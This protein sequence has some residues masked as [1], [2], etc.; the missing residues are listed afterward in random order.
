MDNPGRSLYFGGS[1]HVDGIRAPDQEEEEEDEEENRKREAEIQG[2]LANAF[3]DLEDDESF[4]Q[5]SGYNSFAFGKERRDSAYY[6]D[7]RGRKEEG[8]EASYRHYDAG[9]GQGD[10]VFDRFGSESQDKR[11]EFANREIYSEGFSEHEQLGNGILNGD[12]PSQANSSGSV[13]P[14]SDDS[15][16]EE[17]SQRF[18]PLAYHETAHDPYHITAH[19]EHT[20]LDLDP[21]DYRPD[22]HKDYRETS[23][24]Y[25]NQVADYQ[26]DKY[27]SLVN[28]ETQE[29]VTEADFRAADTPQDQMKLLYEARGRELDRLSSELS[30]LKF[31]SSRDIRV[32]QHQINLVTSDSESKTANINQLQTLLSEKEERIKSMAGDLK[33]LQNKLSTKENENKKLHFELETAQSTLSSLECQIS[34]LKAADTLTRNQKLHEDFVTKLKQGNEE[35]RE[36]LINKLQDAQNQAEQNQKEVTRLREELRSLRATYDESLVQK[37]EAVTKLTVTNET[38]RRQ[39]EDLMKSH[40]GQQIIELQIKVRSL[41]AIKEKLENQVCSLESEVEKAK[42]E[43]DG[44]D[45]AIKLGILSEVIPGE[46]SMVQ[47]GIKKALNYDD[48]IPGERQAAGEKYTEAQEKLKL[49]DELKRSLMS[50]KAKRDEICH[51]QEEASGKQLQIKKLESELKSAQ[52]EIKELKTNLLRMELA[53]EEKQLKEKKETKTDDG[54]LTAVCAE[55]IGLKEE[56]ILLH[57]SLRGFEE[58]FTAVKN[59]VENY[60]Q[61]LPNLSQETYNECMRRFD[62]LNAIADL[63]SISVKDVKHY[64]DKISEMRDKNNNI[65]KKQALWEKQVDSVERKLKVFE[66]MIVSA[67]SDKGSGS[68]YGHAVNVLER[69]LKDFIEQTGFVKDDIRTLHST[70]LSLKD[71]LTKA[72]LQVVE[73][74]RAISSL[75]KEKD[76]HEKNMDILAEEKE[77]E[78]K[79]ALGDCQDTYMRFHEDAMKELETKMRK[80]YENISDI[81]KKEVARLAD[82][83]SD[84]KKMYISVCEEKKE[85]ED[86][87]KVKKGDNTEFSETPVIQSNTYRVS[88]HDSGVDFNSC[89]KTGSVPRDQ[90]LYTKKIQDLQ[91]EIATLKEASQKENE[92]IELLK[93]SLQVQFEQRL[94]VETEAARR[95]VLKSL[96]TLQ[97]KCSTLEECNQ[98]LKDSCTS[99]EEELQ[100]VKETNNN[101]ETCSKEIENCRYILERQ[102][103]QFEKKEDE[104][105]LQHEKE[106]GDFKNL[107][108]ATKSKK[109]QEAETVE[110]YKK[111]LAEQDKQIKSVIEDFARVKNKLEAK[112]AESEQE[113]QRMTDIILNLESEVKEQQEEKNY[114]RANFQKMIQD[115]QNDLV[116]VKQSLKISEDRLKEYKD[117]DTKYKSMKQKF[118]KFQASSK[119]QIT[120]YKRELNRLNTEY[121]KAKE[122]LL[123]RVKH[124]IEEIRGKCVLCIDNTVLTLQNV[125]STKHP[126]DNIITK[127]QA[128]SR[129]LKS[130]SLQLMSKMTAVSTA[131]SLDALEE[132]FRN[133]IAALQI[134][135]DLRG[136]WK[137]DTVIEFGQLKQ[138]LQSIR[139]E[140]LRFR[141]IITNSKKDLLTAR[142]LLDHMQELCTRL[143]HM[144]T[145]LPSHLPRANGNPPATKALPEQVVTDNSK[146]EKAPAN[147]QEKPA[148]KKE[149]GKSSQIPTLTYATVK[150]FNDVPKYI[151]GRLQYEQVNVAIDEF[152]K[153]LEA[154]YTLMRRPRAK[155]SEVDMK[156]FT[157]CRQQE[158][159]ETKGLFFVV[160]ND[161]KR[162]SGLKLDSNG[163][164]MMTVLRTLRRIREVRGPGSLV[165]F[166][167]L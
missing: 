85:L 159:Q 142:S 135:A 154:K 16:D 163:R 57:G 138:E 74:Q 153:T 26:A 90:L 29:K 83:L 46:D 143:A 119:E 146:K 47:L 48:T 39:Y 14:W 50:N 54:E 120:Y 36:M 126:I 13:T 164:S 167:V 69:L 4:A 93:E 144:K 72:K 157:A 155:L 165:R 133:K 32:L 68:E 91:A 141:A 40:D 125:E 156:V 35:E 145:N 1:I 37:T 109:L 86:Q 97:K 70:E 150:E 118:A 61:Y 88:P 41:E 122:T 102:R 18:A 110:E 3:D 79:E 17:S 131:P 55:N 101:S 11:V 31:E 151:R 21:S 60:Q 80:E 113:V 87:L 64:H 15:H 25:D 128:F 94:K 71:Q 42:E 10:Y 148:P 105:R 121:S 67:K 45:T 158:N 139:Q 103:K 112:E 28:R 7:G 92:R 95:E 123:E 134:C 12:H 38:L 66:N 108:A 30:K 8:S 100:A 19:D 132:G 137:E 162:W 20:G 27:R 2:M 59:V 52:T 33:E 49:K 96:E 116:L 149:P 43:I 84:T 56:L 106:I 9:D 161:I 78:K 58:S 62:K 111:K 129:E 124:F 114:T 73:L 65:Q 89:Q 107:L 136:G 152:N 75:K 81:L 115:L 44:F 160:D 22:A 104:L 51:L 53:Q 5:Q 98:I 76:L 117:L 23:I 63:C 77:K 147:N 166:A 99:L 34:E 24:V 127:L 140:I 6:E 82:E 130:F